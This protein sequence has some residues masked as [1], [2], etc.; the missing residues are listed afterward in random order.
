MTSRPSMPPAQVALIPCLPTCH[1]RKANISIKHFLSSKD[2]AL[3]SSDGVTTYGGLKINKSILP[4][5]F[6]WKQ[7]TLKNILNKYLWIKSSKIFLQMT[8][9]ISE[10]TESTMALLTFAVSIVALHAIILMSVLLKISK[11]VISRN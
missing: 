10:F 1:R 6:G 7:E 5:I 2:V 9:T 4:L 11:P 8:H 3:T